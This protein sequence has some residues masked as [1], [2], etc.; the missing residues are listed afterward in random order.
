MNILFGNLKPL[1]MPGYSVLLVLLF[2]GSFYFFLKDDY[3]LWKKSKNIDGLDGGQAIRLFQ[4]LKINR[5]YFLLEV[6][7]IF[8]IYFLAFALIIDVLKIELPKN[9]ILFIAPV[10]FLFLLINRIKFR[11]RKSIEIY[12]NVGQA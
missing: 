10:F 12:K 2:C 4:K 9:T 7:A 5:F 11:I 3:L 1:I 6:I 8:G